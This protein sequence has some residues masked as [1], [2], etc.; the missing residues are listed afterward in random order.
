MNNKKIIA[1]F[2]FSSGLDLIV[3]FT[4]EDWGKIMNGLQNN[5]RDHIT[6]G[7]KWGIDFSH[8]THYEI[9]D[10]EF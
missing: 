10:G 2:Y 3:T 9:I 6:I 7:P 8:M 4:Q 1:K 5:W